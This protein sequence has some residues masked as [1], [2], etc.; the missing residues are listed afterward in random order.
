L[1]LLPLR[2]KLGLGPELVSDAERADLKAKLIAACEKDELGPFYEKV[3]ADLGWPKDVAFAVKLNTANQKRL[4]EINAKI[5]DAEENQG[6]IEVRE[7]LLLK[8]TQNPC[9]F[10]FF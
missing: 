9:L 6:E 3:V 8:V 5:K 10:C 2:F 4:D 7:S 1:S